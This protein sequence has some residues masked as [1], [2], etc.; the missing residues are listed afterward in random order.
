MGNRILKFGFGE[1]KLHRIVAHCDT[2]DYGS[3]RFIE[4]IGM[5][6]EGCFI[7]GGSANK[8][9]DKKFGVEY[10]YAILRDEWKKR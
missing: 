8:F 7:E 10:S 5:C 6:R 2:E 1:L 9:S 3:Y 4:R